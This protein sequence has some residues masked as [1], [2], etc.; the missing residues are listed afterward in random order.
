VG[1]SL[2]RV[3]GDVQLSDLASVEVDTRD[4]ELRIE[5]VNGPVRGEHRDGQA[6]VTRVGDL[7]LSMRSGDVRLEHAQGAVECIVA[8][9]RLELRDAGGVTR[10]ELERTETDLADL[11]GRVTI[12]ARDSRVTLLDHRHPVEF[13]GERSHFSVALAAP[14]ELRATSRDEGVEVTLGRDVGARLDLQAE[15][16]NI[17]VPD[18]TL[19]IQRSNAVQK[20]L[21]E[22]GEGGAA[23]TVRTERGDIVVRR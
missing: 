11:H 20:V 18:P 22:I 19:P 4:G 2:Q 5:D 15:D 10:L 7:R 17:R 16:G 12:E 6:E 13:E 21:G 14:A 1:V 23:L 9:G 8:D 3:R